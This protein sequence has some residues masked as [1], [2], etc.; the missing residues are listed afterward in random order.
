MRPGPVE[1]VQRTMDATELFKAG[2]LTEALRAQTHVVRSHPADASARRLLVLLL[3]FAGEYT[4]ASTAVEALEAQAGQAD[5]TNVL[6][7]SLLAAE[8]M[9]ESVLE[10][11]GT[12]LVGDSPPAHLRARLRALAA[13]RQG[14]LE[15]LEKCLD[16]AAASTPT[17]QGRL[18]DAPLDALRDDDDLLG[19]V[20][21]VFAG[22]RYLWLPLEQIRSLTLA[23]PASALD[24][25]W[26]PA[27]L[28]THDGVEAQVHVPAL[29][30][31]SARQSDDALRLGRSTTW[32]DVGRGIQRGA[33]QRMLRSALAGEARE[34]PLLEVRSLTCEPPSP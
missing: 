18:D 26:A 15:Q 8:Q 29:Y 1:E 33:G 31:G 3:A 19:S 12:P 2:Q 16:E 27:A 4:R 34:W 32:T 17:L 14:D 20:L 10:R 22:G 25:L 5:W 13:A 23:A 21:E 9:R 28:E 6:L 30:A 7:R 11:E 24:L